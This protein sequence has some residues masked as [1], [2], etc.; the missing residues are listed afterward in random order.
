MPGF[1]VWQYFTGPGGFSEMIPKFLY[2]ADYDPKRTLI[3]LE[4][5]LKDLP[6][7]NMF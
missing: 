5:P 2:V 4:I 7:G 3:F 6:R 1:T